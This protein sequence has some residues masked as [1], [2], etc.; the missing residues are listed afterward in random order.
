VKYVGCGVLA[1]AV[2]QDKHFAK[3]ICEAAGLKVAPWVTIRLDSRVVSGKKRLPKNYR[4]PDD[5]LEKIKVFSNNWKAPIFVKPARGGSS[6]GVSKVTKESEL[7]KAL[8]TALNEDVKVIIEQGIEGREIEC[9][10]VGNQKS[11]QTS[12]LG[13]IKVNKTNFYDYKSKYVSARAAELIVDPP[14]DS[15]N[16]VKLLETAEA[17]FRAM[18]CEGLSRVD[19]FLT[20]NGDVY[21]NEINTLPGF[22]NISMYPTLLQHD[23]LKYSELID[24][25]IDEALSREVG[26]R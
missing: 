22:T 4:L 11:F 8:E 10:I 20:P 19:M 24:R 18:D 12:T 3:T 7:M 9:A 25:L 1:S 17:V 2:G 6:L 16:R 13:E 14:M 26:L 5:V 15:V 23:G 21:V